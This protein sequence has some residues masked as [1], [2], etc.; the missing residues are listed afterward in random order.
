M[1]LINA[2]HECGGWGKD[3]VH[4]D[5]DGFLWAELDAFADD[6]DELAD[7]EIC[8]H[9]ILLLVDGRNVA[10]LD[11]LADYLSVCC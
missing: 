8:W 5:K 3:L 6:V 11:L 9:E 2:T 4:E 7:G 1:F 10:L